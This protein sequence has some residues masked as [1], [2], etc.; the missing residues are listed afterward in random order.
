MNSDPVYLESIRSLE[1]VVGVGR[2]TSEKLKT[3]FESEEVALETI[4]EGDILEIAKTPGISFADASRIVKKNI[5]KEYES[6]EVLKTDSLD[7]IYQR[8]LDKVKSRA[9]TDYGRSRLDIYYPSSSEERIREVRDWVENVREMKVKED[10]DEIKNVKPLEEPKNFDIFDRIIL[11]EDFET[12]ERIQNEVSG[13]PVNSVEDPQEIRR[14]FEDYQNVFLV[15]E[16]LKGLGLQSEK[17]NHLNT[18]LED[19]THIFPE[20]TI[21]YFTENLDSIESSLEVFNKVK[22]SLF[23]DISEEEVGCLESLLGKIDSEGVLASD[24]EVERL[25]KASENLGQ[26]IEKKKEK[27]NAELES[28]VSEKE[29]KIE[30]TEITNLLRNRQKVE[31]IV[32]SELAEDYEDIVKRITEDIIEELDLRGKEEELARELFSIELKIPLKPDEEIKKKMV[33]KLDDKLSQRSLESKRGFARELEDYKDLAEELVGLVLELDVA[34]AVK[35]FSEDFDMNMAELSGS[36]TEILNGD[37]LFIDNSD[38]IDYKIENVRLLTGVNSGGKTSTLDLIAQFYLL[39]QMGFPVPAEEAE[40]SLVEKIYY[41]RNI[42]KTMSTGALEHIL[43]RFDDL[44]SSDEKKL[45]LIDELENITEPGA[46][47]KI[48]SGILD[49]LKE[50]E[51]IA[52]FVSHLA[53]KIRDKTEK[54][55][56][57]DGIQPEGLDENLNLKVDRTPKR[58][59]LAMSTPE[60]IVEKLSEKNDSEFYEKLSEKF[61]DKDSDRA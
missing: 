8:L 9:Q 59:L 34:M 33:Q 18:P 30:G 1:E 5:K 44:L 23:S 26:V 28:L 49:F 13:I 47:A 32:K 7:K 12:S 22:T 29:I 27:A 50:G 2:K 16:K 52:V 19:V 43:I 4:K 61:E 53:D 3:H 11:T 46:S 45:V 14:Y 54:D 51:D 42:K 36:G 35:N 15:G 31:E 57:V 10:I 20:K 39:T 21:A 17:I 56:P 55:I 24:E 37:N 6:D 41:Y 58:N 40:I 25:E 60:L 48:M 38:S